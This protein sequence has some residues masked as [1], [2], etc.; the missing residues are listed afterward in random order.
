MKF[1]YILLVS[2]SLTLPASTV[3]YSS[4]YIDVINITEIKNSSIVVDG[5][6]ITDIKKG[7]IQL[8]KDDILID[9]RGMTLMPGFMDMHVH[10]GQEY[11]SKAERPVKVERETSAILAT[12]H[13]LKT[14]KAGF[15]TVRQVGDS[16]M[17]AISLRDTI[18]SG[19]IIGPRIF[20]SGKSIATTGGHAQPIDRCR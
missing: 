7:F 19:K 9:L 13:A 12:S 1:L 11:V 20:T 8:S 16:G 10:F 5:N 15:T 18:N 3:I 6:K 17:V 2:I 4:S 14:L